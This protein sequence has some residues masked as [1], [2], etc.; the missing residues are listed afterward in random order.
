MER[1]TRDE[2][3]GWLLAILPAAAVVLVAGWWALWFQ[4]DDAYIAF[5][6]VSSRHLGWGYT[7]NPPPFHPVEGYTSFLW[8]ALLDAVWTLLGVAPPDSA[9]VI[10]L[11]AAYGS[12]VA[13]TAMVWR[14][15]W[16]PAF[17][18]YR[19]LWVVVVLLGTLTNRTFV[20]WTSSGLEAPLFTFLLLLWLLVAVYRPRGRGWTFEVVGVAS[21]VA[22]C[23]PDGLLFLGMTALVVLAARRGRLG[24]ADVLG[25]A[26]VGLVVAH[27]LW[28]RATYGY[29]LPNT[30]YAK[31]S[32]WWPDAGLQYLALF[33]V[34]Y[35]WWAWIPVVA[36]AVRRPWAPWSDA[37]ATRLA[38][39]AVGLHLAYYVLRV[40]GDHFEFRI[41]AHLPPILWLLLVRALDLA[42]LRPRRA[43]VLAHSFVPL[44]WVV[45]W[46]DW[47][48]MLPV[49]A[50]AEIK[51]LRVPIADRFPE[52]LASYARLHDRLQDALVRHSIAAP[53]QTH[54]WF[55]IHKLAAFG[56]RDANLVRFPAE[57]W[58]PGTTGPEAYPVTV[59]SSVGVAGWELP[60]VAVLDSL[61]LN[62]LVI[63]RTPIPPNRFRRMA[64]SRVAPPGYLDCFEPNVAALGRFRVK[65]RAAPMTWERLSA[66]ESTWLEKAA[67]GELGPGGETPDDDD[68]AAAD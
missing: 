52:P 55:A 68:E 42:E 54:K 27:L 48:A 46:T 11:L 22:L 40:G 67:A 18:P 60:T 23:R 65:D 24:V 37:L 38:W 2:G 5:R 14:T 15:P 12:V 21:L 62:D 45:A 19:P 64:H 63:A 59:L 49:T 32:F 57:G 10:G 41:F 4:C 7:W 50:Y 26:P 66:C 47:H 3:T 51:R 44:T 43:F 30:W 61:G 17:A 34:E 53:W 31:D 58:A 16:S 6:Y 33:V 25:A 29:W 8:V 1:P 36:L 28:R 56:E 20:T 9:T 13:I 39:G 35:A